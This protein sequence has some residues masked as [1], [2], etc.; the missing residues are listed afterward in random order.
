MF[1]LYNIKIQ[2]EAVML[3]DNSELQLI[4]WPLVDAYSASSVLEATFV[5]LHQ[6]PASHALLMGKVL[7]ERC[8]LVP[9]AGLTSAKNW[10]TLSTSLAA[11]RVGS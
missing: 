8:T 6:Q 7:E 9:F 11:C 4:Y 10:E 2:S 5:A 3:L 1:G